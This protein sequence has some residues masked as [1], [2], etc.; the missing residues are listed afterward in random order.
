M[1]ELLNRHESK[2]CI[3]IPVIVRECS[4]DIHPFAKLKALPKD[5]KA[6]ATNYQGKEDLAYTEV[7]NAIIA[8]LSDSIAAQPNLERYAVQEL[9]KKAKDA[10]KDH[11]NPIAICPSCCMRINLGDLVHSGKKLEPL[12]LAMDVSN[13]GC[14]D[15]GAFLTRLCNRLAICAGRCGFS[16]HIPESKHTLG[17]PHCNAMLRYFNKD[18]TE[19]SLFVEGSEAQDV[20]KVLQKFNKNETK[21]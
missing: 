7:C 3:V 13:L 5:G 21:Q 2:S 15:C 14:P 10:T 9:T 11:S 8:V 4:W 17:C 16:E 1:S 12:K 20:L 19:M 18:G 6:I